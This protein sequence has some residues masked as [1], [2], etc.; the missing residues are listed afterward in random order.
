[1][2]KLIFILFLAFSVFPTESDTDIRK[3]ITAHDDFR[4]T[5]GTIGLI[6]SFIVVEC[7]ATNA[8][9]N[10]EWR[11]RNT[12]FLIGSTLGMVCFTWEIKSGLRLKRIK[13]HSRE[14]L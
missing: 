7:T 8:V 12:C 5:W 2:K 1:M 3:A 4:A 6:V 11:Q 13:Q 10:S 14:V 9:A